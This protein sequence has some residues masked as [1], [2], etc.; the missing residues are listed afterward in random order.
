MKDVLAPSLG[1]LY[2]W[3][4][5]ISF[6]IDITRFDTLCAQKKFLLFFIFMAK[7]VVGFLYLL[8][9]T[10]QGAAQVCL[11]IPPPQWSEVFLKNKIKKTAAG[12]KFLGSLYFEKFNNFLK[13]KLKILRF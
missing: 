3:D 8:S 10:R 12:E 2:L 9:I 13:K 1:C 7:F 5:W 4:L 6:K 11:W